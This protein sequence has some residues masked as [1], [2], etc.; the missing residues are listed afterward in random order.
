M[1]T[2]CCPAVHAGTD[3][4]P[5]CTYVRTCWVMRYSNYRNILIDSLIQRYRF[6]FWPQMQVILTVHITKVW[7]IFEK[8][9]NCSKNINQVINSYYSPGQTIFTFYIVVLYIAHMHMH[10]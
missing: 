8:I 7:I 3:L 6:S 2:G 5:A 9:Q 10:D 4:I 1:D